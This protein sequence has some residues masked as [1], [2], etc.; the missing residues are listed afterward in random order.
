MVVVRIVR[1]V[2]CIFSVFVFLVLAVLLHLFSALAL[3]RF[4]WRIFAYLNLLLARTLRLISGTR[5]IIRGATNIPQTTG[6]LILSNHLTYLDGIVLGSIFPVIYLSKL[7][8]KQWF[9]I[10][11][12][13]SV[14]GTILIDRRKKTEAPSY[15]GRI[16]DNLMGG[17]NVLVFPEGTSTDGKKLRPFQTSLFEAP[18]AAK[19]YILPVTIHYTR[20]ND[21]PISAANCD[22]VYWYGQIPFRKHLWRLLRCR[23]I[24][25]V[26]SLLPIFDTRRFQDP[27]L[28]RK[29]LADFTSGIIAAEYAKKPS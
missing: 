29:A 24:E 12:M 18:L 16:A 9:L 17:V 27:A 23:N 14:S 21:E 4:R 2:L 11:W 6:L 5:I 3:F 13:V 1:I 25:A 26:V 15:V 10:G 28:G 20:I 7:A 8:V 19:A 22:T